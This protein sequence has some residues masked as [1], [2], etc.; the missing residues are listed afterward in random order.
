MTT[1]LTSA[2]ARVRF[3]LDDTDSNPLV[4]DADI[5]LALSVAQEE[6][7]QLV[8][9]SGAN[10]FYQ[11]ATLTSTATGGVNVGSLKPLKIANVAKVVDNYRV[12][13]PPARFYDNYTNI[14][15]PIDIVVTYVPRATFPAL[16]ADEFVWSQST[17]SL[18]TL[19][20][21]MIH[22]AASQC[23]ARTGEPPNAAIEKRKQELMDSINTL[24]SIPSWSAT[25]VGATDRGLRDSGM[26]W[27]RVA[28]DALQII[29]GG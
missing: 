10:I 23:W 3:L 19:D 24:V 22:V 13:I 7:W 12:Q 18:T 11:Q 9:T 17:I 8:I 28:H 2:I 29:Y 4:S 20:Q 27:I 15:Q 1:T 5:T 21:L 25:P 14:Q 16:P 26:S 6:V